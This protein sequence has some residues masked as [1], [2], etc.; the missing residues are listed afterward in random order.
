[1]TTDVRR[2][3]ALGDPQ[4]RAEVFFAVLDHHGLRGPSGDLADGVVLL[5]IGDHFDFI[6]ADPVADAAE[7]LRI[8]SWLAAQDPARTILLLGNHDT[9]RV[10]ELIGQTDASFAAA[11]ALAVPARTPVGVAP[12]G[13]TPADGAARAATEEFHRRCP[14][15][16]PPGLVAR[17]YATFREAQRDLVVRLLLADRFR[18]AAVGRTASGRDVLL[19]HAGVTRRE[20]R[21]LGLEGSRDATAIATALNRFLAERVATV[22]PA[23]ERRAL[24]PLDLEPL[25]LAGVPRHEGGGLLYHRPASPDPTARPEA[26]LAWELDPERPRRFDPRTLP[27]GLIQACGHVRHLTSLRELRPWAEPAAAQAVPGTLRSLVV[28]GDAVT[29]AARLVDPDVEPGVARDPDAACLYLI[30]GEMARTP[31]ADFQVLELDG[32]TAP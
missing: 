11:R 7:G 5:S 10:Q 17:D 25:H 31:P 13:V 9:A 8:L 24:R 23:W 14:D 18:L 4:A 29:Y 3:V 27:S 1:V 30:D 22:R 21:L 26:D 32:L 15:L 12:G 28:R 20:L 6:G 16:P 2:W 19:T